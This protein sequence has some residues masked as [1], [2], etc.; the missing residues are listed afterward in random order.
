MKKYLIKSN[1]KKYMDLEIETD[2]PVKK[3]KEA[4]IDGAELKEIKNGR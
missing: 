1:N 3:I 4:I 2:V